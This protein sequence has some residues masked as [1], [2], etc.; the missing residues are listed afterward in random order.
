MGSNTF[1]SLFLN[2]GTLESVGGDWDPG[3]GNIQLVIGSAGGTIRSVLQSQVSINDGPAQL[4]GSGDLTFTGGGRYNLTGGTPSFP[5]FGGKVTV[6]GGILSVGNNNNTTTNVLGGRSEQT[7]TLKP[8]SGIINN[9]GFGLGA[10]GLPNNIVA[11]GNNEFYALAGSR[12]YSG[13]IKLNGTNTIALLER[14]NLVSERQIYF[15]GRVSG[16]NVTLNVFGVR[17]DAAQPFY[18]TSGSN[19]LTGT[20]NLNTNAVMEVR[21]PGSVGL[22][23]GD[24]TVN[25]LGANSKLF[26]RHFQNGDFKTNVVASNNA[27]INS[28]RLVNYAGG[29]LQIL[30]INDL[31]LNGDNNILTVG[32]G[33]TY[34][35]RVA[36]TATFNAPTNTILNV[37]GSDLVLENG[38]T[39]GTPGST[40]DKRG[41]FT[42]I[43]RGPTNHTGKLIIQQGLIHL[44]DNGT[45]AGTSAIELRGG[46]LRVDNSAVTNT[47][48]IND[49]APITLGGGVLRLTGVET[50]G[51]VSAVA[52]TTIVVNNPI[53]ETVPNP[54]TLTGFT[55]SLG[56]VVQ[57]Q[58]PDTGAAAL[59]V[60]QNT[61]AQTRVGS[62]IYIPGQANT[63]QT[64]PGFVGN[65]NV[66]FVQY[67]GTTMDSGF[68]LGVQDM[69][70]P[71]N[72]NS[73]QNYTNDPAETAWNDSVI[74]RMTNGTD[75]TRS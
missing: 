6:N 49:A 60:G 73:P 46:E 42:A 62:R 11:E 12:V 26:L 71:G 54:L 66:D 63:T 16:E 3:T 37:T 39:F 13:D 23:P 36:G 1:R 40:L 25:L 41:G 75:S 22:N 52:G 67:D 27:E 45:L 20:I 64:I 58:S 31:T 72:V 21:S 56:A 29:G 53:N 59:A 8:G 33:N 47:N 14:D 10:N 68:A 7:I 4:T 55:R 69:R 17:G 2:G 70:N 50:L 18:L 5:N 61:F 51:T 65:N 28:D 44:Q 30:S 43:L 32:G 19:T 74:A 15:N 34:H 24:V 35:T 38:L 48:R 57:F 9:V